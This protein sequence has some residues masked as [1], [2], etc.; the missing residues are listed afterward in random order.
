MVIKRKLL[1]ENLPELWKNASSVT[2][3]GAQQL[4]EPTN[5][6]IIHTYDH[7][8]QKCTPDAARPQMNVND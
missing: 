5:I 3:L 1:R 4:S 2:P 6:D 8:P 7:R